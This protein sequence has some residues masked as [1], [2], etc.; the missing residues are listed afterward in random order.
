MALIFSL[1]LALAPDLKTLPH[2]EVMSRVAESSLVATI[3]M[4]T[5]A[6]IARLAGGALAGFA[7]RTL[8]VLSTKAGEWA[9]EKIRIFSGGL[10]T[11]ASL[12]DFLL[13]A[14]ISMTMWAMIVVAL[15]LRGA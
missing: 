8:G 7:R 10:N 15:R 3:A 4:A 2:H 12:W 1:A 14:A 13:A 11:L 9:A 5:F 6:I